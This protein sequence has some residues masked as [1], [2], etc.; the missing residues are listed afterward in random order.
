MEKNVCE[1][2]LGTMMNIDGKTKDSLNARLDLQ[3]MNAK[4]ELHPIEENGKV[5]LP[6]ACYTLSD[7]DRRLLCHWLSNLK[8]PDGYSGNLSRCVNAVQTSISGMKSHDYHVFM[9]R[10]LPLI[11]REL[12]PK[13]V[14]DVVIELS[15]FF[16]ALCAKVLTV[17]DLDCLEKQMLF[18]LSKLEKIFVPAFFD[19]MVHLPIHL[20]WEARVTGPV[21][22]SWMYPIERYI[23]C[24]LFTYILIDNLYCNL[25]NNYTILFFVEICTS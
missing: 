3:V 20:A 23:Y 5:V 4:H 1:S 10:L 25:F 22:Y 2:L 13:H 17:E 14:A 21:Q 12:F 11:V 6:S 7:D 19:I 9:E 16:K 18:T 8:V 24:F 15:Y